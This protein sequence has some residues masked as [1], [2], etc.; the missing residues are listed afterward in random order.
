MILQCLSLPPPPRFTYI[1]AFTH[2]TQYTN[3]N[4]WF[5]IATQNNGSIMTFSHIFWLIL[6]SI[7]SPPCLL[8]ALFFLL[9]APLL[10]SCPMLP[11]PLFYFP[12]STLLKMS[13]SVSHSV[14]VCIEIYIPYICQMICETWEDIMDI[15]GKAQLQSFLFFFSSVISFLIS[16]VLCSLES[17]SWAS[18]GSFVSPCAFLVSCLCSFFS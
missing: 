17:L 12:F 10:S 8:L 4:K 18:V 14:C 7:L 3:D 5:L 11:S 15:T 9:T 6:F 13:A 2:Y 16:I 1:P